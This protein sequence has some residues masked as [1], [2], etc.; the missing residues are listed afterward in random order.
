MEIN[1]LASDNLALI[2]E[3]LDLLLKPL[4]EICSSQVLHKL[5]AR[6]LTQLQRFLEVATLV[7]YVVAIDET[8]EGCQL[9][10]DQVLETDQ[11]FLLNFLRQLQNVSRGRGCEKGR[12]CV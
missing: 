6:C 8:G 2:C 5:Q 7:Q 3:H 4:H 1:P 12:V 9:F 11:F 10:A